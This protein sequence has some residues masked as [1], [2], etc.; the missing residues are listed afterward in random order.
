MFVGKAIHAVNKDGRVSLPSRM[1]E[2]INKRYSSD[3]L[4][5][6]L[7][8]EKFI[9][10][11]PSEEFERLT[12]RFDNSSATTLSRIMDMER[13]MCSEA[14]LCKIDG[15]GRI[16]IPPEMKESAKINNEVIFIGARSHI[17]I[18]NPE[19]WNWKQT[20]RGSDRIAIPAA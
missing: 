10:L 18:W 9:C 11:F 2:V 19:H 20:Q 17:E 1:R 12:S 6:M 8:P 16:V 5:L 4:Y 15:S 3:D 14:E 13:D 7:M